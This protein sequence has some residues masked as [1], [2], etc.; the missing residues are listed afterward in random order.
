MGIERV[1]ISLKGALNVG[2]L[3]VHSPGDTV[4]GTLEVV[5]TSD[6]QELECKYIRVFLLKESFNS[7]LFI[8]AIIIKFKGDAEVGWTEEKTS[9]GDKS[10]KSKQSECSATAT[11]LDL[12][13]PLISIEGH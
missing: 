9:G 5:T 3:N 2:G 10:K 12:R 7:F 11:C 6:G 13:I 1:S 4:T 8:A